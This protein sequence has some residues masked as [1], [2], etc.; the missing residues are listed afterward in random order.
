MRNGLQKGIGE[1]SISIVKCRDESHQRSSRR[2]VRVKNAKEIDHGRERPFGA[3]A[4]SGG[5][6]AE[7]KG[8]VK[9]SHEARGRH[10]H[11]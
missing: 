9:E 2:Y 6:A 7:L 10:P 4:R 3:L 8:A 11:A 5:E 1:P